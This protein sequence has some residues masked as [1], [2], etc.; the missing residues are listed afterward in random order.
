MAR[1]GR[2]APRSGADPGLVSQISEELDVFQREFTKTISTVNSDSSVGEIMLAIEE[3]QQQVYQFK[4]YR[5]DLYRNYL[6]PG[7]RDYDRLRQVA[8]DLEASCSQ[9]IQE[10]RDFIYRIEHQDP[11]PWSPLRQFWRRYWWS[12][13]DIDSHQ[14]TPQLLFAIKALRDLAKDI[15]RH[16]ITRSATDPAYQGLENRASRQSEEYRD[17]VK[18]RQQAA[19]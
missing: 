19:A 2:Y 10:M 9:A 14:P 7:I 12:T 4:A 15:Q 3:L 18:A 16:P 1:K 11:I 13:K 6:A 8:A 5:L 17:W